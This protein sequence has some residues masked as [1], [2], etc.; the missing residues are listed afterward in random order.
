MGMGGN[1]SYGI[2]SIIR[3]TNNSSH[4]ARHSASDRGGRKRHEGCLCIAQPSW[5][6]RGLETGTLQERNRAQTHSHPKKRSTEG[7]RE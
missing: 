1:Q 5:A 3:G 4:M 6:S 2:W 7:S